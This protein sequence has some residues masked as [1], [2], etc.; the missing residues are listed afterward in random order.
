MLSNKDKKMKKAPLKQE[1]KKE[2]AK[3]PLVK[4]TAK[5]TTKALKQMPNKKPTQSKKYGSPVDEYKGLK[6]A[7][8]NPVGGEGR[9][10]PFEQKK[11]V[12]KKK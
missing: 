6:D 7:W 3:K 8:G 5:P 2:V 4:N 10:P 11:S 1:K 12:N 9:R